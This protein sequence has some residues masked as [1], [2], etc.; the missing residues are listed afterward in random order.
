LRDALIIFL[1]F[2]ALYR[3]AATIIGI[4][5]EPD[6][7]QRYS[8]SPICVMPPIRECP[9]AEPMRLRFHGTENSF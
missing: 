4:R 8:K 3:D 6:D 9:M 5:V 1:E 7:I 2:A